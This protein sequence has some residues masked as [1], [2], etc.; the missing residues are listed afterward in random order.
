MDQHSIEQA[1]ADICKQ[2]GHQFL[3]C[4]IDSILGIAVH[5][6]GHQTL[7]GLRH[8]PEGNT[9]GWYIWGGKHSSASDF[10]SPQHTAH[11]LEKAPKLMNYFGLPPG[12]R[13]LL[14]KDFADVWFDSALL[15]T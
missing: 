13:F 9:N 11:L 2:Y 5:T 7:N 15:N 1:Q 12:C 3:A 8:E 14:A 10:F 4:P 6:L